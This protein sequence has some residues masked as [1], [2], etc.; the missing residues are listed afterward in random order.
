MVGDFPTG[1][2]VATF[3][4]VHRIDVAVGVFGVSLNGDDSHDGLVREVRSDRNRRDVLVDRTVSFRPLQ[5][6]PAR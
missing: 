2:S 1:E 6:V 4:V 3:T 5:Q